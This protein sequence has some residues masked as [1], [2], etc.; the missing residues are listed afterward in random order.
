MILQFGRFPP[1]S[2]ITRMVWRQDVGGT[3]GRRRHDTGPPL[4][5]PGTFFTSSAWCQPRDGPIDAVVAGHMAVDRSLFFFWAPLAVSSW[6]RTTSV[7]KQIRIEVRKI[8]IDAA[9]YK[10]V[11]D[12]GPLDMLAELVNGETAT[13]V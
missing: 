4:E 5:I 10:P 2:N 8:G 6:R 11:G 1:E 13:F 7:L 9:A 12:K 3:G